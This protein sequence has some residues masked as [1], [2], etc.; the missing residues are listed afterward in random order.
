MQDADRLDALGA[1]GIFR[2]ASCGVTMGASY[3]H[4]EDPFAENRELDDKSYTIDHFYRKLLK[5]PDQMNTA[6]ARA[7]AHRR[8]EFMR[9]F[10]AEFKQEISSESL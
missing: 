1:V 2:T 5:L 3:Y 10:L 9:Q 6:A 4:P 7:E 8:A